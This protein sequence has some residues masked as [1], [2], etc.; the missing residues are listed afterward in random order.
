MNFEE[1]LLHIMSD[2]ICFSYLWLNDDDDDDNNNDDY[3]DDENEQDLVNEEETNDDDD[4]DCEDGDGDKIN[5]MKIMLIL[6]KW[7]SCISL[8]CPFNCYPLGKCGCY[9][10][11]FC[12]AFLSVVGPKC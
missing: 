8:P 11:L 10:L 12:F 9:K 5:M 2:L 1:L 4:H 6:N 3:N 7:L